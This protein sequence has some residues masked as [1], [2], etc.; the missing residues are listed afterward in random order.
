ME[1]IFSLSFCVTATLTVI[2]EAAGPVILI[3]TIE[4]LISSHISPP[5]PVPTKYGRIS[6][7]VCEGH[8]IFQ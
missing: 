3:L 5:P 1:G 4:S 2:T 7:S 6:L 8:S